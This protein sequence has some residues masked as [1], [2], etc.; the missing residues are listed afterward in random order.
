MKV[1]SVVAI[2]AILAVSAHGG[3]LTE[4]LAKIIPSFATGFVING[5]EAEPHSAP[6]IVSLATNFAKHSHICG[7]TIINKD[8][9]VTAAHCISNPV[10]M[11]AIAGLHT[12]AEVDELTQ[13]RLIDFGRVHEQYT[14][15]VGPYDI[16]LLHVSEPFIFNE[17]VSPATLPTREEKHNGETHLYGWGQPKSYVL[18]AA[19]TLQT[20]TTEIVN[21]S[22]CKEALP[23]TAPLVESNICSASLE[24]SISACN[25]DSGG[26]LV[27][28]QEN[29]A[30]ELIGVVSWGYI[31]CGLANLPSVYTRV[32]AYV[33]WISKI[34]SA[35][36]I[37]Y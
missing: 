27:V 7:G 36:Y 9:I 15:G 34:Q 26:P 28:E 20:V 18:T 4:N 11:S 13:Q 2:V 32:S 17:W 5:T 14:G 1:L 8:W 31:P 25:G 6:Y 35:Y 19:K 24:Q 22:E 33:D 16:A 12:R 37:L 23:D 10:N 21:F 29:A 3:K 30:S